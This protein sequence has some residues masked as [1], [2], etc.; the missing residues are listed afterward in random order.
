MAQSATFALW[1][2]LVVCAPE[3]GGAA[4]AATRRRV[5]GGLSPVSRQRRGDGSGSGSGGDDDDEPVASCPCAVY[6]ADG[7]P[8]CAEDAPECAALPASHCTDA[9]IG[10]SVRAAC[11]AKCG[12]CA[13]EPETDLHESSDSGSGEVSARA[14]CAAGTPEK[15]V[16]A[17]VSGRCTPRKCRAT[18]QTRRRQRRLSALGACAARP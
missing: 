7:V 12:L 8:V 10:A 4:V 6:G 3:C 15:M 11:P 14:C 1:L 13:E 17:C 18:Q 5:A 2:A 9:L 16:P